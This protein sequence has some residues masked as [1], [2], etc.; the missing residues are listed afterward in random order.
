M[1]RIIIFCAS[2]L[3]FLNSYSQESANVQFGKA[4][5]EELTMTH[6][7]SDSSAD[8]AILYENGNVDIS[9]DAFSEITTIYHTRIKILKTSGLERGNIVL[10][11]RIKGLE[12]EKVDEIEGFSYNLENGKLV[13][14]SIAAS[15][16]FLENVSSLQVN[17]KV[18]FP[19]VKVGT[20]IELR[21]RRRTPFSIRIAPENWYFQSNI[22]IAWSEL[23]VSM[24]PELSYSCLY[25]GYLP[26]HIKNIGDN[27]SRLETKIG[28]KYRFVIKDAPAFKDESYITSSEDY[29]SKIEFQI[30]SYY[31]EQKE[32]VIG[33]SD[34]WVSIAKYLN[35]H[36]RFGK[37]LENTNYLK[38]VAKTI[39]IMPD[40]LE[41]IN[42]AL[43]YITNN[44]SWNKVF[45]V[46]A[47][48]D[49]KTV[50]EN[51][52]GSVSE[53]NLLLLALLNKVGV[54][55]QASILSTRSNGE[56][57]EAFPKLDKF[58]YVIVCARLNGKDLFIDA[59]EKFSTPG[60]IPI[61]CLNSRLCVLLKDT[62][63]LA[64]IIPAKSTSVIIID[65]QLDSLSQKISGQF[66]KTCNAYYS[67]DNRKDILEYGEKELLK[68]Y[69]DKNPDWQIRK[70][71]IENKDKS[72]EKFKLSF[73][74]EDDVD[75]T[76]KEAVA[77]IP[78]F[79]EVISENPF[80]EKDRIYPIN[81]FYPFDKIMLLKIKIP[82][83]FNVSELPKSKSIILPNQAGKFSYIVEQDDSMISIKSQITISRT[84]FNP[85][86]Y[87]SLKA[88]YD[89]IILKHA[90]Q[91]V[92]KRITKK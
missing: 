68:E 90:E 78:F 25:S 87:E 20:V 29:I 33:F 30:L 74:F 86:E 59:T 42:A 75:N 39:S 37:R 51:K 64:P 36:E 55:A 47:K 28:S 52:T 3:L 8:A 70:F 18:I 46:L 49:L 5:T 31:A 24:P 14:K 53:L 2:L 91:I 10:S 43:S 62:L 66:V 92:F 61:R 76:K 41:R 82:S 83:G 27:K 13:T 63:R 84:S 44:F 7:A 48:D 72:F 16:I 69:N 81:L 23:N 26:F 67:L 9:F 11:I 54:N 89:Q 4:S 88:F 73:D 15:N 17:K 50:F 79:A 12:K 1:I 60:L 45:S 19:N 58:N 85:N 21:Y 80:K 6:W 71:Y 35:E 57:S 32:K 77:I 40:T 56:I 34:T 65:A 22:P 38:E